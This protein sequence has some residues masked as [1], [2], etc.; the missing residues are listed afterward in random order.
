MYLE[1]RVS[2]RP[3][4]E[5]CDIEIKLIAERVVAVLYE[6]IWKAA[7]LMLGVTKIPKCI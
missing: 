5:G 4:L 7:P 6:E 3:H 2:T 1:Y